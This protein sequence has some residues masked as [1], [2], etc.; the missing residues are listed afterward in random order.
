MT[1][2]TINLLT[3]MHFYRTNRLC[4]DNLSVSRKKHMHEF[5]IILV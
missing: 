1:N 3:A 2:N 4:G 5:G